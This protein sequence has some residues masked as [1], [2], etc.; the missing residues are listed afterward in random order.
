MKIVFTSIFQSG[1]GG[2]AGRVAHELAHHFALVH[3]VVMVCPADKTGIIEDESGLQI[4][5]IRSAGDAEFQMPDLSSKAVRQLFGFL[6][7]FQ[8]DI[9]HAHEP[10]LMGLIGQIWAKMNQVP[11]VH[12]THVLPSKAV[13]FGTSEAIHVPSPILKSSL[14]DYAIKNVLGNFFR[15]C[16]ALI[17]LNKSALESI[18]D[19]GFEGPVFVVPNGRALAHYNQRPFA[20]NSS[21][22]KV[23]VFIGFL[24]DRK[25]QL[26]LLKTLKALPDNYTLRLVGK[27][28]NSEYQIKLEKYIQKYNLKN[29]EFVGQINHEQI[30]DFLEGAHVFPSASK[31]EV[32]SLVVIEAL[33]SGTP[34]VG[35]SNETIDELVSE[36][37]GAWLA[38][39]QKPAM[40]AAQ[41]ERICNLPPDDYL[42]ICQNAQDRVK[43]L[44]WSTIVTSTVEAYRE[45]LKIKL[46]VSDDES[47]MLT[48]LV[49]FFTLGDLRDYL[50]D[51]IDETRQSPTAE[52]SL[53]P[54]VK[55]PLKMQS[56]IRVPSSTW[57]IS[58][59]TIVVS[60]V[61]YF[62]MRGRGDKKGD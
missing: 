16:D 8:P 24:S 58:G 59:L 41:I 60:V 57:L 7:V 53:L 9:I 33:A 47:D 22:Q 26:Y 18:R 52:A 21:K 35:L 50:I 48:S 44:D 49:R 19:F 20:D 6:D 62:F 54:R 10:A 28:L 29:V 30:P 39:D 61:S 17:A 3:E 2:G 25:N 55:V 36:D 4:Y 45:I 37:V 56:W 46:A 31:M 12:T 42:E 34:V 23:L 5:G 43:H 32:Q 38:K 27:P 14:T 1:H 51:V 15:N 13:E 11:F 40:F